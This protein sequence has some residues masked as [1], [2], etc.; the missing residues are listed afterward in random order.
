MFYTVEKSNLSLLQLFLIRKA[1][2]EEIK[3]LSSTFY[4]DVI[5]TWFAALSSLLAINLHEDH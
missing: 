3:S 4:Y 2:S 5:R 1:S